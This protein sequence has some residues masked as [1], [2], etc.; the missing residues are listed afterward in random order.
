M[1][2]GRATGTPVLRRMNT[3]AVLDAVRRSAP[4]P[5]RI[6]ELAEATGLTRPTV[7]HAVDE[8][9]VA[10]WLLEHAPSTGGRSGGRPAVRVS[11][12]GRAAP[13]LGLDVGPHTVT[14]GVADATGVALSVAHRRVRRRGAKH[15]LQL[16]QD[17]H[18][19]ALAS[20]G[21][22]TADIAM[23][24][25]GTPGIVDAATGRVVYAPSLP[26][27]TA[28]DLVQHLT[29]TFDCPILIENDA[30]L[31]A[32]A[33]AQA[34]AHDG[35]VLAVR[36]GERL[37]AGVIIDGRLH[38]GAGAAGEIGFIRLPGAEPPARGGRGPLE[39]TVGAEAIVELARREADGHP[40]SPLAT[41]KADAAAVFAAAAAGD[42]VATA[43]VERVASTFAEALAPALLT[44]CP[45]AVIVSGGVARAGDVLL[46]ALRRHLTELTLIPPRVELSTLAEN[47]TL[48][49]AFHTALDHVW[50]RELS[51][52]RT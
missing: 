49:G 46:D 25:V 52:E 48:T 4:E 11:L 26:G 38:R 5:R 12:N 28:I 37:G 6:A 35:T 34:H 39:R 20:A 30:D 8:L 7:A 32:L 41:G 36:W 45:D 21:L 19:E 47:A 18:R 16:V 9:V 10:G 51:L 29:P 40:E 43:V 31:A 2:I 23:V 17:A 42:A 22:T 15:V 1:T 3:I 13:V 50:Q 33:V 44:L 27:W 14:A 24:V